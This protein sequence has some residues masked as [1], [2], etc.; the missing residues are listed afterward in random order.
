[1]EDWTPQDVCK[2][3][4]ANGVD[5]ADAEK[6]HVQ[7]IKGEHLLLG[8]IK[9]DLKECE[10]SVGGRRTLLNAIEAHTS[11]PNRQGMHLIFSLYT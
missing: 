9:D 3:A 2:W 11:I 6:L 1:M 10:L 4:I 5:A 8:T 7:G